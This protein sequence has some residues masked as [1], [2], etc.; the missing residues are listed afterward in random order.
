[1]MARLWLVGVLVVGCYGAHPAVDV[2]CSPTGACPAGQMCV[3]DRCVLDGT[4][5]D[6]RSVDDALVDGRPVDGRADAKP[7]AM[8]PAITYKSMTTAT[9][10]QT[11]PAMSVTVAHPT[12]AAGDV[13]VAAIAM[14]NT[15]AATN[16]V[17]TPPS[18]WTL[19][20]RSDH[21]NDTALLVYWHAVV[22]AEP[23]TYTWQFSTMIEG[24]AWISCYENVDLTTP[25]D[26]E[27][28]GVIATT[29]PSY[30]APSITPTRPNTMLVV[31]Y[32]SHAPTSTGTT[33]IAPAQTNQRV[34]FNNGTTRSG[35]SVDRLLATAN[36]TGTPAA[37]ASEAQDYALV[38]SLALRQAP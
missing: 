5:E 29:G 25:I 37:V 28:G 2:P 12:C 27:Q 16:P 20:R 22:A 26:V 6:A 4:I 21:G 35:T 11:L 19:V 15:G 1:M 34:N 24:V 38:E 13:M 23:T 30:A 8:P 32:V 3:A 10:L 14:G 18:G 36:P 33:W 17:F 9:V 7:D 31:T